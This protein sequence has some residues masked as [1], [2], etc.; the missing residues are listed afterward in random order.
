MTESEIYEG[1]QRIFNDLF[2]DDSIV[3]TADLSARDVVGWD[4]MKQVELLMAAEETFQVTFRPKDVD[5]LN[6]IGD[7]V[8]VIGSSSVG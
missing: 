8:G 5:G 1:L 6:S 2:P 4:S 3:L 7:L